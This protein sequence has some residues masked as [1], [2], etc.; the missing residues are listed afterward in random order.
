MLQEKILNFYVTKN[1]SSLK[2]QTQ[3]RR[4]KRGQKVL[5]K[6]RTKARIMRKAAF[7]GRQMIQIQT[8]IAK[9]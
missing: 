9:V 1:I 3:T 6:V 4:A 5:S 8:A 2:A 7:W